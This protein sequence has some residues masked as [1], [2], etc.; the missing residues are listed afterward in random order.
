MLFD[1]VLISGAPIIL[2][3][4][5]LSF[6][7]LVSSSPKLCTFAKLY[8]LAHLRMTVWLFITTLTIAVYSNPKVISTASVILFFAA[9][10]FWN[11]FMYLR[12]TNR[13]KESKYVF[14]GAGFWDDP[15][16]LDRFVPV[17]RITACAIGAIAV[18]HFIGELNDNLDFSSIDFQEIV[19]ALSLL[20][21]II[22][23]IMLSCACAYHNVKQNIILYC[24]QRFHSSIDLFFPP[25]EEEPED[26]YDEYDE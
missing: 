14:D 1:A 7:K 4:I 26:E 17:I 21:F 16:A 2:F 6:R 9:E 22:G 3:I 8:S 11:T 10:I 24:Y 15:K 13:I 20:L 23:A 12:I 19:N 5:L 18:L 25:D